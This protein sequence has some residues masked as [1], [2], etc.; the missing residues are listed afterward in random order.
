MTTGVTGRETSVTL[1]ATITAYGMKEDGVMKDMTAD[2]AGGGSC[3][4]PGTSIRSQSTRILTPISRQLQWHRNVRSNR[5]RHHHPSTGIFAQSRTP[6]TRTLKP[7]RVAGK[8][9]YPH[10]RPMTWER[11]AIDQR[12][13]EEV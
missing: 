9:S 2:W 10:L 5:S 4:G 8:R 11:L 7:A 3:R 13:S 1:T 6:T 12:N